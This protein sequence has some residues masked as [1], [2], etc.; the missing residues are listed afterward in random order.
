MVDVRALQDVA[1]R[2]LKTIVQVDQYDHKLD[3]Y[4]QCNDQSRAPHTCELAN[5]GKRLNRTTVILRR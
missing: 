4:M 1:Q 3:R 5:R 2:Q